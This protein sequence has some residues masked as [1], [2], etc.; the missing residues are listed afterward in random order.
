MLD[1]LKFLDIKGNIR[2][3]KNAT[4]TNNKLIQEMLY[5]LSVVFETGILNSMKESKHISI[6]FDETTDC[7]VTEQ[8]AVHGRFINKETGALESH[9]LKVMD[10]LGPEIASVNSEEQADIENA[11]SVSEYL[12]TQTNLDW[13]WIN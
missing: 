11:I 8:L 4:Y 12:N 1:L 6:M 3:A 5:C 13:T 9:F 7:T 10:V 2:I